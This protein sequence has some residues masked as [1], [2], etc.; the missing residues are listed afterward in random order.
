MVRKINIEPKLFTVKNYNNKNIF[1]IDEGRYGS[2]WQG[3]LGDQD[4]AVKI[5]PSHCQSYFLNEREIYSLPFMEHASLLHYYGIKN[6]CK[7]IIN[8]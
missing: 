7:E 1:N 6:F 8:F 5:F 3:N 4:V 2:V